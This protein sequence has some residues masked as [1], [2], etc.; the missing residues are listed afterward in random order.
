MRHLGICRSAVVSY[1][2]VRSALRWPLLT[3]GLFGPA[4][5][6]A[7]TAAQI[8]PARYF[9]NGK[10]GHLS[11]VLH[12]EMSSTWVV[13][14]RDPKGLSKALASLGGPRNPD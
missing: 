4:T 10:D 6:V 13:P 2:E 11:R 14:A 3:W 12:P 7:V 5:A 1:Q 9:S 8:R